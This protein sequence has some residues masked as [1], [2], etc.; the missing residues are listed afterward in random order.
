MDEI[1]ADEFGLNHPQMRFVQDA[2]PGTDEQG[3]S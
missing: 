1:W 3:Y 2:T